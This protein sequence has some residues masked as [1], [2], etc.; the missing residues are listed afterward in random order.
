M[1]GAALKDL[2]LLHGVNLDMLG[3]RD[4]EVYGRLTFS[5][6]EEYVT[7]EGAAHGFD[8]HCYQTNHEGGLIEKLHKLAGEGAGADAV[9]INPGAW[10][11]YSY[12]IRDAL[13]LLSVPVAEV[14]LSAIEER[15]EWRR[16][17]VIADVVT[18]RISGQGAE[19]YKEAVVALA[20]AL[21]T[22]DTP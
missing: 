14:H 15:E 7:G 2:W 11:H 19:G 13:E 10:T 21:Q 3:R 12:A 5:E 6:L 9:I 20:A 16:T 18:L 22:K 8:V 17:S 1:A 4:P